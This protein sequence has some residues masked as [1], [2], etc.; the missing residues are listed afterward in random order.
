MD[1]NNLFRHPQMQANVGANTPKNILTW[2]LKKEGGTVYS[3]LPLSLNLSGVLKRH[4]LQA[5]EKACWQRKT[6]QVQAILRIGQLPGEGLMCM[7]LLTGGK[8]IERME[9]ELEKFNI[10]RGGGLFQPDPHQ[11]SFTIVYP[12]VLL[13]N[14]FCWKYQDFSHYGCRLENNEISSKPVMLAL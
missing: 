3:Q 8:V 14:T 13:S 1:T 10:R 9:G 2:W 6:Q 7:T 5:C 12:H 11:P 4:W